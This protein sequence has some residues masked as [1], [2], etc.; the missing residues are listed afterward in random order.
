MSSGSM[1]GHVCGEPGCRMEAFCL[2]V[3]SVSRR[4]RTEERGRDLLHVLE[5]F[6]ATPAR[7]LPLIIIFARAAD[8]YSA[9]AT[10]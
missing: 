10:T 5:E 9:I 3:G 2:D 7:D 4:R 6:F 1:C 8:G